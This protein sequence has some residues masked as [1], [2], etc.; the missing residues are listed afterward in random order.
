M[1][2]E[3]K[4]CSVEGCNNNA[5]YKAGGAVGLCRPHYKKKIKYGDACHVNGRRSL[6]LDWIKAN[7]GHSLDECLIW[8][9]YRTKHGYGELSSSEFSKL[10][11]RV[12]CMMAHGH[13][14]NIGMD[15]AHSCGNGHLG[16]VN[17]K[18]L[19]WDTRSGNF[20]DKLAHG[21][22]NRGEKSPLAKL[23][24]SDVNEIRKLRGKVTQQS[25]A[26]RFGVDPSNICKIQR[27]VS[28]SY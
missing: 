24:E 23:S 14:E 2:S 21:T 15:V 7:V 22:D 11:H 5:H 16:C 8:P 28:W 25:L 13:P 10:A 26:D 12:M 17:P 27:G 4:H 20:K 18:H 19:R 6:A 9:F 3:F 1:D